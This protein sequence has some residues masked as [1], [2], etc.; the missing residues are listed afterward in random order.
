MKQR[1]YYI[2]K[3]LNVPGLGNA[4]VEK[5]LD[6]CHHKGISIKDLYMFRG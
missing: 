5:I 4:K 6:H 2:L 3:L 1:E